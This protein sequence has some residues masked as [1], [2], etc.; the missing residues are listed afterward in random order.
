MGQKNTGNKNGTVIGID[1]GT[2]GIA[3]AY[4]FLNEKS[5]PTQ[6]L[7]NGQGNQNKISAEIILDD[8]LNVI[9]FGDDCPSYYDLINEKNYH[10]F[11]KIKMNLYNKK[12]KVKARNSNKEVDIQF[13]IKL[14][15]IEIKNKA[16]EQIKLNVINFDE[17]NIHWVI[18]VPA[19]WDLKSKQIMINAAQE[20]GMIREDDD[21]SNFFALEP[22]AASIYYQSSPQANQEIKDSEDPFIVCDFGGGTVDIV[23][24]KK[25]RNSWGLQFI[26]E[27][28]PIGGNNG[29]NKINEYF[30]ERIIK[31]LFGEKCFNEAKINICKNRYNDWIE[32]ENKIEEFKKKFTKKEFIICK[33]SIDCDIFQEYCK[34]DIKELI[35]KFNEKHKDYELIFDKNWKIFFPFKFIYDL[36]NELTDKISGYILE[37]IENVKKVETIIFTGGASVNPIMRQLIQDKIKYKNLNIVQSHNPEVAISYGSVLFAYDHNIITPRKAKYSFGIK[38]NVKWDE[39]LHHNGGKKVN[40]EFNNSYCKNYFSKFIDKNESISSD[41][42]IV[43]SYEMISP[44]ITIK[45]YKTEYENIMFIDEEDEKGNLKIFKFAELII[46]VGYN[47][48]FSKRDTLVKMKIGGTFISVEAI[49]CKT[50]ES[51]KA[52]CLFD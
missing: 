30:M 29:C 21:I 46:D 36:M 51:A 41:K 50:G 14:M 7:F 43:N 1:F 22:E 12:Y 16:I 4:G 40:D 52:Y 25:I 19:I 47:Y 5:I 42:E 31:D 3:C 2:S 24:H 20:A 15:L 26:E 9:A 32:F 13:I 10:H 27:Y 37:I 39:K 18:T 23:T 11:Y 8:N 17:K 44:K 34:E 35:M 38:C 49:Y 33:R 28:P 48:D 45:L 6:V